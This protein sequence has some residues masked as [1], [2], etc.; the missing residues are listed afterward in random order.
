MALIREDQ[1]TARVRAI[2]PKLMKVEAAAAVEVE[3]APSLIQSAH[4]SWQIPN[5]RGTTWE[6]MQLQPTC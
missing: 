4:P 2:H 5:N 3:E 6:T 1:P